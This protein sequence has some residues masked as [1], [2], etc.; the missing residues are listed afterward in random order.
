MIMK[1]TF[2]DL[3]GE[4]C[5]HGVP[6]METQVGR[7]KLKVVSEYLGT[8]DNDPDYCYQCVVNA[9]IKLDRRPKVV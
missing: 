8:D 9:L 4:E 1:K 7:V 2:C 3:C 6:K 5:D